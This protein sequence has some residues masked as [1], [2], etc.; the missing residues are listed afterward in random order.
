MVIV[1]FHLNTELSAFVEAA[2][3]CNHILNDYCFNKRQLVYYFRNAKF[4]N[5]LKKKIYTD[6]NSI[7]FIWLNSIF[8]DLEIA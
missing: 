4:I 3:G 7:F 8:C 5:A 2:E 6:I 1:V